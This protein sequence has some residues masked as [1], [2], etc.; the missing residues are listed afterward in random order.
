VS[1]W[2]VNGSRIAA[3]IVGN[4][5]LIKHSRKGTFH[6]RVIALRGEWLDVVIVEGRAGAM[7][8]Y[9]ECEVGDDLTV[10]DTLCQLTS[11]PS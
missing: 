6:G 10:R 9:N 5:Y 1:N 7:C 8:S 3:P 11:V 2:I 4:T